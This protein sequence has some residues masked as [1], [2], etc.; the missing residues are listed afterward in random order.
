MRTR[1]IQWLLV[2][3]VALLLAWAAWRI[4]Q[5]PPPAEQSR[6]ATP[7][8]AVEVI[9]LT[10]A[11]HSIRLYAYGRIAAKDPLDV[12]PQ[13]GGRIVRL[14]P[15]FQAG[16][17][18]RAGEEL[19]DIDDSDYRLTLEA[20]QSALDKAQARLAIEGGKRQVAKEELRLLANSMVLD[21]RSRSLA[22]RAPQLR[23]ARA[24]VLSARNA[25]ARARLQLARTRF[26]LPKDV[27]V[28]QRDRPEGELV[29]RGDRLGRVA[30]AAQAQITLQLD[31]AQLDY[32][33]HNDDGTAGNTVTILYQGTR[34]PGRLVRTLRQLSPK[35]RLAQVLVE[36]D[37]PFGLQA[38]HA[39]RPPLL[40]GSYVEARIPAG[41][42]PHSIA[43]PRTRLRDNRRVWVVD[44]D[45]RLQVR[46]I[47]PLFEEPEQV[48]SA[49]LP[50]GD[51]LLAG[52]PAGLL[53]GT[54]VRIQTS[55]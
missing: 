11:E 30:S 54:P 37:D 34:Y 22:L 40:I 21:Q 32:L 36:I 18:I 3:A 53:P 49:P 14:H 1:S 29:D 17:L 19:V 46:T 4:Q 31:P 15:A 5:T 8:P 48:F 42:L 43:I 35:T 26:S 23:E 52:N 41:S 50:T 33:Q 25:V 39:G 24:D 9:P 27:I 55:P 10:P 2:L 47:E 12:R 7:A 16:G 20:A 38:E 45:K 13:V 51:R 44:A 28:L 6:P